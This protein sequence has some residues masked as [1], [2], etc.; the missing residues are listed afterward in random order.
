MSARILMPL[1]A[2]VVLSA[3]TAGAVSALAD[4]WPTTPPLPSKHPVPGWTYELTYD[5]NTG[6][7]LSVVA[8]DASGPPFYGAVGGRTASV[9]G[10]D[11]AIM[12]VSKHLEL[13]GIMADVDGYYVDVGHA[14]VKRRPGYSGPSGATPSGS[15]GL[16][17]RYLPPL[18]L[19]LAAGTA[20]LTRKRWKG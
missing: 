8:Y 3:V 10:P 11:Q 14:D 12:D 6:K 15:S 18:L 5:V 9:A 13:A 4:G 16:E 20:F 2:A 1:V 19:G 17:W 7:V